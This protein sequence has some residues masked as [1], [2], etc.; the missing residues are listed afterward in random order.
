[1]PLKKSN[2]LSAAFVC[3]VIA[4]GTYSDGNGLTLRVDSSGKRWDQRVTIN[5]RR[6][7]MGL[8]DYPAAPLA[9][10]RE[11]AMVNAKSVRNG[12]D[13]I[14]E[15]RQARE[16]ALAPT[17]PTFAEASHR[18]I[19]SRRSTWRNHKHA[20]QWS[21]TLET[22]AYPIIGKRPVDQVTTADI[23]YEKPKPVMERWAEYL[24]LPPES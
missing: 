21:S 22:Y 11:Q 5:S 6:R 24:D 18:V 2:S 3:T 4:H 12:L 14:Q 16:L 13:P 7:N 8:G 1:M 23:L 17:I 9:E 10:A 19:E 20:A 15:N